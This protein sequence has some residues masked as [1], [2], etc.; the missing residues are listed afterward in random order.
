MLTNDCEFNLIKLSNNEEAFLS[1]EYNGLKTEKAPGLPLRSWGGPVHHTEHI[2]TNWWAQEQKAFEARK[3][4]V[5]K[6][7]LWRSYGFILVSKKKKALPLLTPPYT[8]TSPHWG[9]G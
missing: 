1:F 6:R 8:T 9:R 4:A 7:T 5:S 3:V 2:F